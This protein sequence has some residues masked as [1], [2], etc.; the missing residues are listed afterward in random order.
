MTRPGVEDL[1]GWHELISDLDGADAWTWSTFDQALHKSENFTAPLE[2]IASEA[3]ILW[4]TSEHG[5]SGPIHTYYP[6]YTFEQVGEWSTGLDSIGVVPTG[7]MYGGSVYGAEVS[8]SCI[9]PTN[10]TRSYSRT[11]YLDPLPPRSNYAVMANAHVTRVI[12]DKST[13][14]DN[15][16]ATEVEYTSDDG[17]TTKK[18]KVNKE[19]VLSSGSIG[20]PTVLLY[21]GVG[22]KNV[23]DDAGIDVVYEL[24]G[25]GQHLQDHIVSAIT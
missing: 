13:G 22:P 1:D 25:V 24:P 6:E 11:G 23:L 21:S 14:A 4:N 12:F 3:H 17:K 5:S 20:S 7:N 18:V 19:V 2:S 15:L 10:L 8:T 16:T 9:N